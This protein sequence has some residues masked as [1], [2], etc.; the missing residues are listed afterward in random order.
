VAV[1]VV[2]PSR[3]IPTYDAA[4]GSG[5]SSIGL[6]S[7]PILCKRAPTQENGKDNPKQQ[8]VLVHDVTL[9]Q[10][11]PNVYQPGHYMFSRRI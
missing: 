3:Q 1:I 6:A 10:F 4:S 7:R 11:T 5:N 8:S 2:Y 9:P